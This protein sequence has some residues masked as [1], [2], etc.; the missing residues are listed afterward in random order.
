MVV[1]ACQGGVLFVYSREKGSDLT[2]QVDRR[3]NRHSESYT[4]LPQTNLLPSSTLL[5]LC[6]PL[7]QSLVRYS[8]MVKTP[9]F[10]LAAAAISGFA[11]LAQGAG[12]EEW[13]SQSIYQVMV[14][15]F[16]RT[17]GSTDAPCVV[18]DFCNGTWA[19]LINKL[20]YIQGKTTGRAAP[21]T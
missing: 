10:T 21:S 8:N 9:S 6:S 5:F 1:S 7:L 14:D 13:R 2:R 17:D 15:R 3:F 11:S 16:A 18:Y 12:L 4:T 20:D 19:G